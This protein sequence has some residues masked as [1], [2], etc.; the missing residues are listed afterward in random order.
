[1]RWHPFFSSILIENEFNL[2]LNPKLDQTFKSISTEAIQQLWD[3]YV[4][5]QHN[6]KS[7]II[8]LRETLNS[9]SRFQALMMSL[10]QQESIQNMFPLAYSKEFKTDSI[11]RM[12]A[13]FFMKA[14]RKLQFWCNSLILQSK[15]IDDIIIDAIKNLETANKDQINDIFENLNMINILTE[16]IS[17]LPTAFVTEYERVKQKTDAYLKLISIENK[18]DKL[19]DNSNE[20]KNLCIQNLNSTAEKLLEFYSDLCNDFEAD[21]QEFHQVV[22]SS[23]HIMLGPKRASG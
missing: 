10:N 19:E 7:A 14:E 21:I 16:N 4:E 8:R 6:F 12:H 11:H 2:E 5:F 17:Q 13:D 20:L 15:V 23:F 3:P 18:P 1:M 22:R 9:M